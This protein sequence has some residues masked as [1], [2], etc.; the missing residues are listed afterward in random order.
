M[1][2]GLQ[3]AGAVLGKDYIVIPD[4]REAIRHALK[5]ATAPDT[6]VVAGKGHEP[7]QVIGNQ[8]LPFDDRV[9]VREL[10]DELDVER[11]R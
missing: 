4:R 1:E 2:A 7:Y 8:T 10:I 11:N 5:S 3:R 6:V 9:V